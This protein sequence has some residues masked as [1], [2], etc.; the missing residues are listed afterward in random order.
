M[1]VTAKSLTDG[2]TYGAQIVNSFGYVMDRTSFGNDDLNN[3]TITLDL[4]VEVHY[5]KTYSLQLT[6]PQDKPMGLR[7]ERAVLV[8]RLPKTAMP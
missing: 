1:N 6:A 8:E 2:A 7:Y 3:G 5:G 4:N